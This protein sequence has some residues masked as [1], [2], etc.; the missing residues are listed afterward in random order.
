[1]SEVNPPPLIQLAGITKL[2]G[3][4]LPGQTLLCVT[5]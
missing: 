3:G 5:A 1:M 4:R 2:Y